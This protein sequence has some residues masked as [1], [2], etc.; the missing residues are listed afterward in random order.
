[1]ATSFI[2]Q[3]AQAQSYN[4]CHELV[5]PFWSPPSIQRTLECLEP[6]FICGFLP[7]HCCLPGCEFDPLCWLARTVTEVTIDG[8]WENVTC[9]VSSVD[10]IFEFWMAD[11]LAS[12][13]DLL[14]PG[15]QEVM[16]AHIETLS[17]G[18]QPL[19][20]AVQEMITVIMDSPLAAH[21]DPPGGY[22]DLR[23]V[24]ARDL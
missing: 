11:Q 8:H 17:A 15:V 21:P 20:H 22:R 12:L 9:E 3:G 7:P 18:E 13:D 14:L 24:L 10:E 6:D 19:P 5:E 4:V 23:G 1:M 16:W 2:P